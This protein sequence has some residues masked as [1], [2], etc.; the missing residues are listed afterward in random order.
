LRQRIREAR[1]AVTAVM[2]TEN[3][4]FE[5]GAYSR[6]RI[7]RLNPAEATAGRFHEGDV[8]E[9]DARLAAPLRAW[10]RIDPKVARG[11]VPLGERA[12]AILKIRAGERVEL[13]SVTTSVRPRV[14]LME[15]A[16]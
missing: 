13:R 1:F 2:A 12:L 3:D 15:A 10:V 8:V 4:V 5:A 6:R 9:F 7:C 14:E 11:T 16:E